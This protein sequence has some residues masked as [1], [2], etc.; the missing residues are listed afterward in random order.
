MAPVLHLLPNS[1][2]ELRPVHGQSAQRELSWLLRSRDDRARPLWEVVL[3][4]S[5]LHALLERLADG[6]ASARSGS[7]QLQVY[8]DADLESSVRAWA[9]Q[10]LSRHALL[11][12]RPAA[13]LHRPAEQPQAMGVQRL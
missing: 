2:L 7:L 6:E 11:L 3:T 4:T 5:A 8:A 10:Q 1:H 13:A 9:G 12:A